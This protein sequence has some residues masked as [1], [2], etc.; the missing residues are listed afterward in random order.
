[1]E[2]SQKVDYLVCLS[3]ETTRTQGDYREQLEIGSEAAINKDELINDSKFPNIIEVN[4][5]SYSLSDMKPDKEQ[6]QYYIKPTN[7]EQLNPKTTE[8]TGVKQDDIDE[9][10]S[11]ESVLSKFNNYVSNSFVLKNKSYRIIT[12]GSWELGI[13]LYVEAKQ[14]RISLA[15]HFTTYFD[16]IQEFRSKYPTDQSPIHKIDQLLEAMKLKRRHD[17]IKSSKVSEILCTNIVRVVHR[18]CKE[19][20]VFILNSNSG[21]I[22]NLA[23]L[24]EEDDK[25]KQDEEIKHEPEAITK[26]EITQQK[27]QELAK[28]EVPA[29]YHTSQTPVSTK[30]EVKGYGTSVYSGGAA[31]SYPAPAYDP[32]VPA[33]HSYGS[34][35]MTSHPPADQYDNRSRDRASY[36]SHPAHSSSNR[37]RTPEPQ[38]RYGTYQDDN[39]IKYVRVKNLPPNCDKNKIIEFFTT[40]PI[41]YANIALVFDQT[42]RFIQ[43]AILA[44]SNMNDQIEA[45]AQSGRYIFNY[46]IDVQEA[47]PAEWETAQQS[48]RVFSKDEKI[49]VRMRGL[50]FNV[51][52]DEVLMFF[53]D[54]QVMPDS[55]IIGEMSNGKKTGEGVIIFKNESEATRAVADKNGAN[56]GKRWIELYL[57]PYSHFHSFFQAQHHEEFV[58]LSK[59]I[60]EENRNRAVRLR[61][62]PFNCSKKDVMM[63]FKQFGVTENDV[64]IEVKESRATGRALVFLSDSMAAM[65]AAQVL[66][67]EYIGNRYIELDQVANLPHEF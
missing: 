56:I 19:G 33:P 41:A 32:N 13:Q 30:E 54:Y 31:N 55:V 48:Q 46:Q 26:V 47:L 15:D 5:I 7:M 42:G 65:R 23:A 53:Q 60:N 4:W 50:P 58:V 57:H 45:R 22:P 28:Q 6:S 38:T 49:L 25:V 43:E 39:A 63:F 35:A 52:K 20:H 17:V 61:G 1:M 27:P 66:D 59:Y 11:L 8:Q 24:C 44:L 21:G 34:H 3:L 64:I 67:K 18:L 14:K 16:V 9:A 12:F 62:L 51:R 40:I 2:A 37:E 29:P 36:Q 10:E